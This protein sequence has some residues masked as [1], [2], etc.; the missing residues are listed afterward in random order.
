MA[1]GLDGLDG[2]ALVNSKKKNPQL[3][4]YTPTDLT[5]KEIQYTLDDPIPLGM[6]G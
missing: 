2:L 5:S 1:T 4:P 3:N 6:D